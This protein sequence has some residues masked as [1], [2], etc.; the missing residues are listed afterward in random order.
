MRADLLL[1]DPPPV[2]K[3]PVW[4]RPRG[5]VLHDADAA[6]AAG[7]ALNSLDNLVR[8]NPPWAGAWRQRLALRNAAVAA[9]LT[10]RRE[11]ESA[12]RDTHYLRGAGDDPG[13]SGHLLMAWRRLANRTTGC[14]AETVRPVAEQHFGLQWD[15]DLAEVVVNAEDMVV[16]SRPAPVLAAEIAAAVYRA[17]PDAELLGFWLADMLL[18]QKFRWPIPVPLLMGQV[19]SPVFKSG[20]NRRRIRP[21]GEGWGRAV[22]LAYATGAAEACDLG[23]ELAQRAATL[24]AVAPKLRAKGSGDVIKLLLSDDAV[25]GSWSSAKL[26]ARGA[27]RLFDRLGELDAVRELSGRPTFRLYGL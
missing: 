5:L 17:R 24:T 22:F 26:S 8:Q 13:P 10:G 12:L 7:A 15:D 23:A 3:V 20:E 19:A 4:A 14:D 27:R 25:P 9:N 2:P 21:G 11:D 1:V 18:A 16:S 6:Y